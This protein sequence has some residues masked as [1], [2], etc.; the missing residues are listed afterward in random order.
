VIP[1]EEGSRKRSVRHT[2]DNEQLSCQIRVSLRVVPY[3][4]VITRRAYRDPRSGDEDD[5]SIWPNDHFLARRYGCQ[6]KSCCLVR[7]DALFVLV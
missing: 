3:K 1:E 5:A 4:K 6:Q 7:R 2:D